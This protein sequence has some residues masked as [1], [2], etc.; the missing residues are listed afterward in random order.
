MGVGDEA[1]I[2]GMRS[3]NAFLEWVLEDLDG[4]ERYVKTG[5]PAWPRLRG[6][7]RPS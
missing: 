2:A 7:G 3:F 6:E 4:R 5:W 1:S